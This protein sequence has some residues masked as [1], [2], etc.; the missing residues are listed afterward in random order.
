LA[1]L[2]EKCKEHDLYLYVDGRDW[3][4]PWRRRHATVDPKTLASLVD[5]FYIGGT[6]NGA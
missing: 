6:K 2:S 3:E 1:A 5:V 4:R